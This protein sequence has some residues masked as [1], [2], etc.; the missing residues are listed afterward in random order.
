MKAEVDNIVSESQS[1]FGEINAKIITTDSEPKVTEVAEGIQ[2]VNSN[3]TD[4]SGAKIYE[5]PNQIVPK[6]VEK[7]SDEELLAMLLENGT[8]EKRLSVSKDLLSAHGEK[9]SF[10]F[11]KNESDLIQYRTTVGDYAAK[12]IAVVSEIIKRVLRENINFSEPVTSSPKVFDL[13][14]EM[15]FLSQEE[16]WLLILNSQNQCQEIIK[17]T[18]G[19]ID[20]SLFDVSLILSNVLRR[21]V[22]RFVV[23]HNHPGGTSLP[24]REDND[25]TDRLL[26]SCKTLGLA[27]LDHLIVFGPRD[28]DY[29]SY[30]DD[31]KLW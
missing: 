4:V 13:V 15:A 1:L 19:T 23:V 20:R 2:D 31:G 16:L 27:L 3:V 14:R 8:E 10:L 5:L 25:A 30:S 17:L 7:F 6:K 26:N 24:S 11:R 22:K 21:G 29:Y 28:T 9:F 18:K 12:R